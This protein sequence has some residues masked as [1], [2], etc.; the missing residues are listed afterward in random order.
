MNSKQQDPSQI[1]KQI[2]AEINKRIH[3]STN[4]RAFT[5]AVGKALDSHLRELKLYKRFITRWL[6]RMDLATKDELAA[7]N[8]KK[9]DV[10]EELD[11][12]DESIYQILSQ[13]KA[14][15][16]KLKM[17]RKSLEEWSAFLN[18]EVSD[19]RS[20]PIQTLENELQELKNLFNMDTN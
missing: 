7:L 15:Q 13:Q 16:Q 19:K 5:V 2:E 11:S 10:V 17:V 14:N 1:Y 12:L 3:A 8:N 20:H 18:S 9:I 4:S 6:N